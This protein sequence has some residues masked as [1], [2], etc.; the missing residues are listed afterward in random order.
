M[1]TPVNEETSNFIAVCWV[2]PP[3]LKV[4]ITSDPKLLVEKTLRILAS[5]VAFRVIVVA[6]AVGTELIKRIVKT[7]FIVNRISSSPNKGNLLS[8][9]G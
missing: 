9:F 2:F 8:S 5:A 4:E 6:K 1:L 3:E 7:D